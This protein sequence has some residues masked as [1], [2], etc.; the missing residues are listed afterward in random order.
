MSK[1]NK[2]TI[3]FSKEYRDVYDLLKSKGNASRYICDLVR[4]SMGKGDIEA[5]IE[6]VVARMLRCQ[7][8]DSKEDDL[9]KAVDS[10]DF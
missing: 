1:Q 7:N 6:S 10:F 3:S 2:I 4:D 5:R 8:P 9:R